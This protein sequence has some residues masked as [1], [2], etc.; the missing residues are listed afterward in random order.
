MRLIPSNQTRGLRQIGSGSLTADRQIITID[1][2][3]GPASEAVLLRVGGSINISVAFATVRALAAQR[4]LSRVDWRLNSNVTLDSVNGQG[5]YAMLGLVRRNLPGTTPPSGV[6]VGANA[7]EAN[8]ILD[9][10]AMD[11]VRPK[12][13]NLKTDVGVAT[14]QIVMQMGALADMFT[15]AGAAT[16]TAVTWSAMLV[17][18]QEARDENGDTPA[19]AFYVKRNTFTQAFSAAPNQ[20]QI[21]LSTGNRLRM[22]SIRVLDNTTGEPLTTALS[23]LRL[24]RA[25]DTRVDVAAL[26]L[27]RWNAACYGSTLQ[28]AQY[29]IDLANPGSL[30]VKYSEFWPI[31]SSA[32]T[33]LVVDGSAACTLEVTTL[34]GVDL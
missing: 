32:D 5:M 33:F 3:R 23:R 18:Y 28:S 13:S 30:G 25:G 20:S 10:A 15:G 2:P 16:Y 7:F 19:P 14:N 27:Q 34:E 29:V 1:V 26:D 12:D 11:N 8:L 9:R 22:I 21:K 4:Y 24:V 31:P 6:G 17:D